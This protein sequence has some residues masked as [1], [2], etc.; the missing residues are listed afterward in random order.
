MTSTCSKPPKEEAY[1]ELRD[2][3]GKAFSI[4]FTQLALSSPQAATRQNCPR[5]G[6]LLKVQGVITKLDWE[7]QSGNFADPF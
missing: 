1:S 4:L 2:K 7:V 6:L 5:P 3:A